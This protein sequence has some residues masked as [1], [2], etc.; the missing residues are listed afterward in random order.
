MRYD[1]DEDDDDGGSVGIG[2]M[3]ALDRRKEEDDNLREWE[4]DRMSIHFLQ[5][6]EQQNMWALMQRIMKVVKRNERS[7]NWIGWVSW[8]VGKSSRD[9][10]V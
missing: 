4:Y 7:L 1:E 9:N 2:L 10:C 3:N 5:K 8:S 6:R